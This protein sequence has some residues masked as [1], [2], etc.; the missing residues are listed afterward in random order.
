[1]FIPGDDSQVEIENPIAVFVD[2][3]RFHLVDLFLCFVRF[4]GQEGRDVTLAAWAGLG[5]NRYYTR[6]GRDSL[7]EIIDV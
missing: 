7:P 5:Q 4:G 3:R 1:V 6:N 2:D